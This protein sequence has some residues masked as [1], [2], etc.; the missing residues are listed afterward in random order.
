MTRKVMDLKGER[1]ESGFFPH[2]N[3]LSKDIED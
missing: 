1:R 2:D 3:P